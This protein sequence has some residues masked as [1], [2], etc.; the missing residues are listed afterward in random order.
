MS[1]PSPLAD[2]IANFHI[3]YNINTVSVTSLSSLL[4]IRRNQCLEVEMKNLKERFVHGSLFCLN[5]VYKYCLLVN[6]TQV[7]SAFCTFLLAS[8]E[9]NGK[10]YSPP[11]KWR[12]IK[13]L[14]VS[15]TEEQILSLKEAAV[16]KNSKLATNCSCI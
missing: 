13:W 5:I 3:H 6:T 4:I 11:R 8:S 7:N 2:P 15:V 1:A 10:Y 12:K 16:P 14:P 9:V